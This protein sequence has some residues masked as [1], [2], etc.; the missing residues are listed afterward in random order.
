M[1]IA[2]NYLELNWFLKCSDMFRFW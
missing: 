1:S 2:S